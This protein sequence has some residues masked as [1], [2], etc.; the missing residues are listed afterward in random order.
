MSKEQ[1][2]LIDRTEKMGKNGT[3]MWR[4]TFQTV[5]SN[6][7]VEMTVDPTYRNFYRQGWD[8]V[9]RDPNPW[10]VYQGLRR[11]DRKTRQGVPVVTADSAPELIY[12]CEDLDQALALA[13]A[14][15][16]YNTPQSHFRRLF[17]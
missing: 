2:I 17:S 9:V 5:N 7:V 13:Q 11:T 10:G 8:H 14:S 1:Y 15:L 4:L 3:T 6:E 16:D 12:R